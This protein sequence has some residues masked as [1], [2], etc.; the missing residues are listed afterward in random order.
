[1][2]N[3]TILAP[4]ILAAAALVG[5][6]ASL[7]VAQTARAQFLPAVLYG[8][9]LRSGQKVEA[10]IDGKSCGSTTVSQ[11]GE[12]VMQIAVEA[13]CA[14]ADGKAIT[15]T[16]N[17][18]AA[19]ADPAAVWHSGGIPAENIATGYSLTVAGGAPQNAPPG[20]ATAGGGTPSGSATSA[21]RTATAGTTATGTAGQASNDSDGSGSS[22]AV[23]I[24]IGVALVAAAAGG[25]Y[26]LYRRNTAG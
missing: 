16:I 9:G 14:P 4:G 3:R 6:L 8:T 21:A 7:I 22:P 20:S 26:Y 11:K 17:G 2:P 12:W 24:I 15:F 18:E 19:N 10:F 25:G 23:F 13:P 1:M 5:V